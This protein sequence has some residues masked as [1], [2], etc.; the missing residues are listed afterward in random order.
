MQRHR[1]SHDGLTLSY[2]DEGA[3]APAIIALHSH[4]MEGVTFE[5]LAAA[6]APD[7]RVIAL[8]Q[9]G[10]GHSDHAASY[11]RNDY[12]GDIDALFAHL[13]L[14]RAVMLGNSLGGVNAYQFAS[15]RPERVRAMIVEDIG[16]TV[17]DD[18]SFAL[19][20]RGTFATREALEA[21]IGDRLAPYLRE[22]YRHTAA[23]WRLAFDPADMVK[24]QEALNGDHWSD[25]LAS[26]C[27]A[28]LIRGL[29]SPV[30][31]EALLVEMQVRRPNTRLVQ[32]EG[33]HVV[34]VDNPRGFIAT[35]S[36][37]L[38]GLGRG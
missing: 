17:G 27:T 30:S 18:G 36:E 3:D 14:E 13:G 4:W 11:T 24:S 22:S 37:F 23:G 35:V 20:W 31:K 1:F 29:G 32:L 28:L 6:L 2:L 21:Q 38:D 10:H 5:P 16:A 19:R 33:G 9:R 8:D 26:S 34:H 12:L 15:R 25:W 7:W